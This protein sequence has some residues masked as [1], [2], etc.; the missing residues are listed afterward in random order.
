MP[1][2]SHGKKVDTSSVA[3]VYTGAKELRRNFAATLDGEACVLVGEKY[4]VRALIIPVPDNGRYWS[5]D[6]KRRMAVLRKRMAAVLD[7]LAPLESIRS[8]EKSFLHSATKAN[9]T[10]E[11]NLPIQG[12][13]PAVCR[14]RLTQV[15]P[16]TCQ[17]SHALRETF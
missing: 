8:P 11:T 5:G 1:M 16:D 17:P 10:R 6:H 9:A 4:R 2:Y 7:K 15:K 13:H 14:K 12:T 3:V